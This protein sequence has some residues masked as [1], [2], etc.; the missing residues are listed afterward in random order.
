MDFKHTLMQ[1]EATNKQHA[2][3]SYFFLEGMEKLEW[4]QEKNNK[5]KSTKCILNCESLHNKIVAHWRWT[6]SFI[7]ILLCENGME[8]ELACSEG[9]QGTRQCDNKKNERR[10]NV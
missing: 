8:N 1:R 4:E 7:C 5:S 3:R 2:R 9:L 10:I 6:L